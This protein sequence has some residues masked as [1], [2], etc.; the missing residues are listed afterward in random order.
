[1]RPYSR[2]RIGTLFLLQNKEIEYSLAGYQNPIGVAEWRNQIA[3]S[4]PEELRSSLPSIEEI[5]KELENCATTR[6]TIRITMIRSGFVCS[7]I[8]TVVFG[9][10][11]SWNFYSHN[12]SDIASGYMVYQKKGK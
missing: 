9:H 8:C 10:S 5:E 2:G 6:C 12:C 11:N 7:Y 4:L 3:K 1:M